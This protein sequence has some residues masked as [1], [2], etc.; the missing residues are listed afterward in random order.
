MM[1]S[2]RS[3]LS[4]AWVC[5]AVV[6]FALLADP[7]ALR[8]QQRPRSVILPPE[9][10]K[11]LT[12]QQQSRE[13]RQRYK[14]LAEGTEQ[15]RKDSKEDMQALDVMTQWLAYRLTWNDTEIIGR[16]GMSRLIGDLERE[17]NTLTKSRPA[18][19]AFVDLFTKR[20]TERL[21]DVLQNERVIA[22]ANG[23]RML[24]LLARFGSDDAVDALVESLKDPQLNDGAKYYALQGLKQ[25]LAR[26]YEASAGEAPKDR[27]EREARVVQA[28]AETVERKPPLDPKL[29]S[30]EEIEGLRIFRREAVRALSQVPT[31][32]V[33]DAKGTLQARPAQALLRVVNNADLSPAVRIDERLE[34]ALGVARLRARL[35]DLYH[36]DYAAHQLGH[37]VV[38]YA[39]MTAREKSTPRLERFPWK[40]Y[41]A[42]LVDAFDGMRADAKGLKDAKAA[43]HVAKVVELAL[44]VLRE[45][46][47]SAQGNASTLKVWLDGNPPPNATT[48]RGLADS[49]V[50]PLSGDIEEAAPAP[51]PVRIPADPAAKPAKPD[52]AAKPAPKKG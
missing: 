12:T 30:P 36:P 14:V 46:E 51:A 50:K 29:L 43:E 15:P 21:K 45:I 28:V 9:G 52:A 33:V 10:S 40:Y 2:R 37:F 17:L 38:Y 47:A 1:L 32:G 4:L 31:P 18:N 26:W 34:A 27:K 11:F 19:Q 23:A 5:S 48:Y 16:D 49:A 39:G 13:L 25:L 22:S 8:G 20:L 35:T 44:P 3:R 42:R 24:G 6:A 41:A 7:A